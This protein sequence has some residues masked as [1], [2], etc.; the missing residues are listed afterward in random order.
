[1]DAFP[2]LLA[3]LGLASSVVLAQSQARTANPGSTDRTNFLNC[4]RGVSGCDV[5]ILNTPDLA[6]VSEAV[7]KRNVDFCLQGSAACDPTRLTE[8][9]AKSVQSARYKRNQ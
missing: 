8:G 6:Q 7:R 9:E 1:M 2:A 3:G 5:S 4:V